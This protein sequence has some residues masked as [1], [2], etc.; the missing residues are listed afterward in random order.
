[1]N[2]MFDNVGSKKCW[3]LIWTMI[4]LTLQKLVGLTWALGVLLLLIKRNERTI[5]NCPRNQHFASEKKKIT[6]NHVI[7]H[8]WSQFNFKTI[9][10][11]CVSA[12]E[13][14]FIYMHSINFIWQQRPRTWMKEEQKKKMNQS[15]W[16]II[17]LITFWMLMWCN[18]IYDC[19]QLL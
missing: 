4:I 5:K 13:Q 6:I 1:M 9:G 8:T 14:N 11:Y 12:S 10:R 17:F 19:K 3:N 7:T 15:L 2:S 16:I 18:E